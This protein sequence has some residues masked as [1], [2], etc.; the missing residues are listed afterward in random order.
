MVELRKF[1]HPSHHRTRKAHGFLGTIINLASKALPTLRP[2]SPPV[3]PTTSARAQP[4]SGPLLHAVGLLEDASRQNNSDALFTLAQLNFFGGYSYP[5]NFKAAFDYYAKLALAHGNSSA[6][7]MLGLMYSTGVGAGIES[8]Q[9]RAQL[10][11]TFAAD[12]GHA[13]AEMTIAH[14]YH[15]GI[16]TPKNCDVAVQYYK[17]VADKAIAWYRSGPPGGMAW[18]SEAHRIADDSGGVYGQGASVSSS[19]INAVKAHPNSDAYASIED[20]I[21]YLDLMSQKGD[22]KASFNLGRIYYEGQRGLDRDFDLARRYFHTVTSKFWK[23]GGRITENFKPGLDKTASKAAGFIGRMFLR[24]EGV[25][26]NF[27]QAKFW[28]DRGLQYSDAQSQYGL[29]LMMLHGYGTGVGAG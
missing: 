25:E 11:Y 13:R 28:F 12:Q 1:L 23:K 6:Q 21:E 5:R 2:S 29:G 14:R 24:G 22:F 4:L 20:I 17:R 18:I 27:K 16:S 19:G 9:A 3:E 10:Y 15:T 26:Q 7:H 8:D